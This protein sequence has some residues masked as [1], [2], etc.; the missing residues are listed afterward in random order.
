V[1]ENETE[2][3][4][5]LRVLAV[6]HAPRAVF[7]AFRNDT[8]DDVEARTEPVNAIVLLAGISSI[9]WAPASGRMLDDPAIDWLLV[10]VLA[11]LTGGLYGLVGY[12]LLGLLLRL[13]VRAEGAVEPRRRARHLVAYASVPLVASL[14]LL[15]PVRLAVFG[16]DIFRS[17]GSDD[18]TGGAVFAAAELACV[19]WSL[20]LLTIAVRVV[21]AWP[22]RR[23]VVAV[24]APALLPAAAIAAALLA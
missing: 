10:I 21:H 22:W 24:A 11:F 23:A 2:R 4:W 17:G 15:L 1:A 6:L 18:G 16:G 5:W 19:A 20:A 7:A 3:R 13:G 14:L 9:L 8:E 12:F